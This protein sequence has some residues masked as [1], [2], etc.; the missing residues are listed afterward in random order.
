MI[1]NL[2]LLQTRLGSETSLE[3]SQFRENAAMDLPLL[4][5][6][7]LLGITLTD[8]FSGLTPYPIG[9]IILSAFLIARLLQLSGRR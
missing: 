6:I 9:W 2:S 8:F 4:V 1:G 7:V 3:L 5:I